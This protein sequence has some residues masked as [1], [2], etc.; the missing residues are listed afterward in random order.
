MSC[1]QSLRESRIS[2][3]LTNLPLHNPNEYITAPEDAMQTDLVPGLN[4]SGG[5][6]NIVI[7]MDVFFRF[8][9]A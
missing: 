9:V 1:E 3:H 4:P 6:E 8:F 2:P 5:L 7:A